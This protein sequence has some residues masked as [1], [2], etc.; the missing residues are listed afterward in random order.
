[1]WP[2]FVNVVQ[3][4]GL[5]AILFL[6][7]PSLVILENVDC[8][9]DTNLQKQMQMHALNFQKKALNV[10]FCKASNVLFVL[11]NE[12]QVSIP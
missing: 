11:E 3:F 10:I 5:Q 12:S 1:M 9:N 2:H 4:K 7:P 6:P 8:I